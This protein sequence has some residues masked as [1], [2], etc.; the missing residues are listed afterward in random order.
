MN[1]PDGL[2]WPIID[3]NTTLIDYEVKLDD[4]EFG[5]WKNKVPVLDIQP[6]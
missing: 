2:V 5:Q 4:G 1:L 6:E 3:S